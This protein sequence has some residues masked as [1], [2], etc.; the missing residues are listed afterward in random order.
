MMKVT[1]TVNKGRPD[2]IYV[3]FCKVLYNIIISK[4]GR[5]EFQGWTTQWIINWM[6]G[7]MATM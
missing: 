4:L 5:Q 1:A 2:V 6:D 7:W 3:D